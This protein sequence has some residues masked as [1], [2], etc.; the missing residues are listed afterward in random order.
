MTPA[1]AVA[2]AGHWTALVDGWYP[3]SS[4]YSL[5]ARPKH[6]AVRKRL[7]NDA[8]DRTGKSLL[9]A[10]AHGW[11]TTGLYGRRFVV[12]FTVMQKGGGRPDGDNLQGSLKHI[13]DTVAK[14]M[15]IDDGDERIEWCYS[16]M[17]GKKC[18][19]LI[20]LDEVLA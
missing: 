9:E 16:W 1:P 4:L 13:R 20:Q 10:A 3:K 8:A 2:R 18:A 12:T 14:F 6:W 17:R 11:P 19:V 15:S 7:E 5:N